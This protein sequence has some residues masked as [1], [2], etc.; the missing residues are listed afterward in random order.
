[1][2]NPGEERRSVLQERLDASLAE[3]DNL[4]E[5]LAARIAECEHLQKI[6]SGER[7]AAVEA[8][9]AAK[10]Q[11]EIAVDALHAAR[12]KLED[13]AAA[14]ERQLRERSKAATA[15]RE[16]QLADA[17]QLAQ[18]LQASLA[19]SEADCKRAQRQCA[20]FVRAQID[21]ADAEIAAL[22]EISSAIRSSKF[23]KFKA[24]ITG[25]PKRKLMSAAIALAAGVSVVAGVA[26]VVLAALRRLPAF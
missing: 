21:S 20:D 10:L 4:R 18:R 16:K 17:E 15:E 14:F 2:G 3:R 7:R 9:A 22:A 1:M 11:H 8:Q 25:S 6:L 26:F 13:Q 24:A 12:A 19:R 5:A 23:W